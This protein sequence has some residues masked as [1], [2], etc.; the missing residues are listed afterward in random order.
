MDTPD[1]RGD[2][3]RPE[4]PANREGVGRSNCSDSRGTNPGA[5]QTPGFNCPTCG[6]NVLDW[7]NNGLESNFFCERCA[8]CWHRASGALRRVNP[9][10]CEGCEHSS[11]C[12]LAYAK[13]ANHPS[14]PARLAYVERWAPE[15]DDLSTNDN[16]R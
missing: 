7:V 15:G 4:E 5:S 14:E 10:T 16:L 13:D 11:R 6:S 3:E 2:L 8:A 12:M 9:G 1:V